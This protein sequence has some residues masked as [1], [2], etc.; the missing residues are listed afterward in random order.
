MSGRERTV[1]RAVIRSL[2]DNDHLDMNA[3]SMSYAVPRDYAD[4]RPKH[5]AAMLLEA[6][7]EQRP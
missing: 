3:L 6:L 1:L 2:R 4:A 5:K 7:L